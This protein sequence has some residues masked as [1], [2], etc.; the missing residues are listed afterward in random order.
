V[1]IA[2]IS[3][4]HANFEAL[5]AVL[6]QIDASE[7]DGI[8]CLGDIIGYGP[9]PLKCID[10]V[11]ERCML[12]LLGNH[13]F[14]CRTEP[15]NFNQLAR[16]AA[17]WTSKKLDTAWPDE[18]SAIRRREFLDGLPVRR[19]FQGDDRIL[20]VHGSSRCPTNEYV[21]PDDS[22]I[23]EHM[24][25]L[26]RGFEAI[27]LQGHT[28]WPGVFIRELVTDDE[29]NET[30]RYDFHPGYRE[31]RRSDGPNGV[32]ITNMGVAEMPLLLS[33]GNKYM[34]NPGSIG[35]PRDGD[36]WACWVI[37]EMPEEAEQDPVLFFRRTYYDWML[38]RDRIRRT[39]EVEDP[40][41]PV[42]GEFLGT[43]LGMGT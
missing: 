8:I 29:G 7:I 23:G 33:Q 28:H 25:V 4:I 10:S 26:F 9:D 21:F 39:Q 27:C 36:R 13:D 32:G 38:V 14:A 18:A 34:I 24:D 31:E 2:I 43:R 5:K 20:C 35:Q 11:Q 40:V 15:R 12:T 16:D 42:L 41:E 22:G 37:L 30:P 19:I 6:A 1:R 3:D 17:L